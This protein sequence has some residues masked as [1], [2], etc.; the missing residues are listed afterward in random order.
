MEMAKVRFLTFITGGIS[1]VLKTGILKRS[2]L[3]LMPSSGFESI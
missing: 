2:G 1:S 3:L